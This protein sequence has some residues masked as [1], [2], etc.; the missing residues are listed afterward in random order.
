MRAVFAGTPEFAARVLSALLAAGHELALV[1]CQP[2]RPAGRGLRLTEC[3]VK[4][5]AALRQLPLL[6]PTTLREAAAIERIAATQPDVLVVAAY[7]LVL[8][9]AVLDIPRHGAINVHASLLPR[10]RGAAPIQRALLGGD[11]ETGITIMKMDAGLDTGPICTQQRIPIEA[12]DDAGSLTDKLAGLGA[13]MLVAA[14]ADIAAGRAQWRAQGGEGASYAAKLAKHEAL[15]DWSRPA[16]E[17]ARKLRAFS[18]QP[19]AQS[20]LRGERIK[21]W[22]AVAGE[23]RGGDP[24]TIVSAGA[25]GVVVACGQGTLRVTELQRPGGRRLSAEELLRGTPLRAGERFESVAAM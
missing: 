24:G 10:W 20:T 12:E 13:E 5:L 2:D 21:L 25:D 8:P 22:R 17:I 23:Q 6:Q 19:G 11:E 14:L 15:V 9:Q 3:P 7:G 18:P 1:L 4:R 16:A